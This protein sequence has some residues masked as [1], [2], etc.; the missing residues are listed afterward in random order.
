MNVTRAAIGALVALLTFTSGCQWLAAPWLMWGPEP[1]KDVPAE[2]PYLADKRVAIVVWADNY[3][4]LEYPFVRLEVSEH[5]REALKA[6][7]RGIKLVSNQ[8]VIARQDR[9]SNWD[10][11]HPSRLGERFKA[12][13]VI[14]VELSTYSTREADS[15]HLLRGRISANVKVYDTAYPDS[16]PAYKTVIE[17]MY[18][19]GQNAEWT[20]RESD[21]RKATMERFAD[22]LSAKFHDRKI[23]VQQ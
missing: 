11:E 5:V 6:G 21:L 15:P 4:L 18:P 9:D 20:V 23:K 16:A 10:R 3:T 19:E 17:T 12:D 8:E 7:V 1:T 14:M 2:Y 13:R 22:A